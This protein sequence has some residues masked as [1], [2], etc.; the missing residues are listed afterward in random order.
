MWESVYET[1]QYSG[2]VFFQVVGARNI[3]NNYG[4]SYTYC[5]GGKYCCGYNKCW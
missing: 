5:D 2:V 3:C 1:I 4:Y